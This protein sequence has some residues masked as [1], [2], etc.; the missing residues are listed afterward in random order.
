M[1]REHINYFAVGLFVVAMVVSFFVAMY[2]VTGRTGPSD[3]YYVHYEN[4]AGLKFGTGVLYEGYRVGQVENIEPEHTDLGTRYRLTLSI[5]RDWRIPSDSVAR[6]VSSGLIAAPQIGISEGAS[7]EK[8]APGDEIVGVAQQNMF[9]ALNSAAGEL[10]HLSRTGVMPLLKNLND[11]VTEIS[12]H[13]VA[14]RQNELSPLVKNID[15]Q[16]NDQLLVDASALMQKLNN[17][18]AQLQTFLNDENREKFAG[19]LSHIDD[20]AINLNALVSRIE[21]TRQQMNG[22]LSSLD[23]LASGNSERVANTLENTNQTVMEAKD[24]LRT[25]NT[26]L[27]SILYHAEGSSRHMHEFSKAIRANPSRLIRSSQQSDPEE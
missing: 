18:A 16:V 22:V 7:A 15:R 27:D 21:Q 4:V 20:V 9:A 24:M 1:K 23:E 26:H 6:V 17:S 10:Q 5:R 2:F 19:F 25:I 3:E 11:R 13:V 14:F 8:L 12:G